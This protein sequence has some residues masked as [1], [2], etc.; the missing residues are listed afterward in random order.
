MPIDVAAAV[1]A[2]VVYRISQKLSNQNDAKRFLF[3]IE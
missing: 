3:Q 2:S 1:R